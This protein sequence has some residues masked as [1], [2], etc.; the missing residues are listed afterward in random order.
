MELYHQDMEEQELFSWASE[1]TM[2]EYIQ[3]QLYTVTGD[4]L[5]VFEAL[6]SEQ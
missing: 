2:L 4:L 3:S 1:L 6:C 5:C